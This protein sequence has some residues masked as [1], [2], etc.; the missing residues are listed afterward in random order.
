MIDFLGIF[1][2]TFWYG[3]SWAGS[4]WFLWLP[5]LLAF[6]F[7]NLWLIQ[8]RFNYLK[9]TPWVLLEIKVPRDIEKS[10]RAM[11]VVITSL[12]S[13]YAGKWWAR[14]LDG[15][16]PSWYSFEI[17][18][19]NGNIHFF[20]YTQK[21][22]RNFVESQVYAQY[23]TAEIVEVND[24][25]YASDFQ[26]FNEWNTMGLELGLSKPDAY[27]I[28]TYV[29]FGLHETLMK[30]EQKVNPLVSFLEFLGTLKQGE[31]IWCQ[32]MFKGAGKQWIEQGKLVVEELLGRKEAVEIGMKKVLS[33]VEQEAI[34]AIERNIS[35]SGF[36]TGVRMMYWAKRD[37]FNGIASRVALVGILNQY[38]S[39]SS[40][41]F[42]VAHS[43]MASF[44]FRGRKEM[45]RKMRMLDAYRK[46]SYFFPPYKGKQMVF[47][48]EELA[49]LYH[50]PGRVATTPTFGRVES[51]KVE[52]PSVLPI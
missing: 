18:S 44:P 12:H 31:Q 32:I 50:F 20:I 23:P 19:I 7:W 38:A 36:S 5:F 13:T 49:T 2:D 9:N 45:R 52:P 17:A 16:L 37:L 22:A 33:K 25:S 35:K 46:R 4:L 26:N 10:P 15:F 3:I 40:N 48:A 34:G 27:P 30:E 1:S 8:V 28:K 42:K 51:K 6:I 43:T 47:N 24:Y 21:F 14:V 41:S 11:E 29:D 39:P